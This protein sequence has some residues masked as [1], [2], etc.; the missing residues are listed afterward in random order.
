MVSGYTC[1]YETVGRVIKYRV[2]WSGFDEDDDTW[3][4][5]A[6]L[7]KYV[8]E[9]IEEYENPKPKTKSRKKKTNK[10]KT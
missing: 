6:S 8:P 9:L 4:T 7:M 5:R 10:K 2:R 3:E 1:W